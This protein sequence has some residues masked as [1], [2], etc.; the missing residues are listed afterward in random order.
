MGQSG[1]AESRIKIICFEAFISPEGCGKLDKSAVLAGPLNGA[2]TSVLFHEPSGLA[3]AVH[4]FTLSSH[5]P[6]TVQ[7]MAGGCR[8][9]QSVTPYL[10]EL[11]VFLYLRV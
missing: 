11:F 4:R 6:Q 7:R 2:K 10:Q 1:K 5:P 9:W 8:Y 3:H